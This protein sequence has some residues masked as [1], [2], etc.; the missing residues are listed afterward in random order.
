MSLILNTA[1]CA[2][3]TVYQYPMITDIQVL[4]IAQELLLFPNILQPVASNE[5][6]RSD[7]DSGLCLC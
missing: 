2:S 5:N 1:I 6:K 7:R 4:L 3:P